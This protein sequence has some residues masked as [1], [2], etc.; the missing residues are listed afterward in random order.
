MAQ[1]FLALYDDPTLFAKLSPDQMEAALEKYMDWSKRS[2][3]LGKR[4]AD[5]SGR[6]LRAPNG[7]PRAA[8]GPYSETKEVLG[9]IFIIEAADYDEAVAF[10]MDHPHLQFGTIELRRLWDE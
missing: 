3:V 4:L 7:I 8:D 10:T 6:V 2:F 1:F 5:D 9:G